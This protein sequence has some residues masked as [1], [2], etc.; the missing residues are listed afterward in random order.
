M[1]VYAAG[2][3][4]L[5]M[6]ALIDQNLLPEKMLEL[7]RVVVTADTVKAHAAR[8]EPDITYPQA[9]RAS[10]IPSVTA[11]APITGQAIQLYKCSWVHPPTALATEFT[12]VVPSTDGVEQV[13]VPAEIEN[14]QYWQQ[15]LFIPRV[16]AV[17]ALKQS[18]VAVYVGAAQNILVKPAKTVVAGTV[19]YEMQADTSERAKAPN[20][21][22][23]FI[24][25]VRDRKSTRLPVTDVS[26]MPSSA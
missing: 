10:P 22:S 1:V 6:I 19:P 17:P 20:K 24:L 21:Q 2:A 8:V 26:R 7:Y 14:E 15:M 16:V 18:P 11:E 25:C 13:L 23:L 3:V 12:V 5:V 4:S 9:T